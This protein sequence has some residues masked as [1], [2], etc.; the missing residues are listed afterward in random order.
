MPK[1]FQEVGSNNWSQA[2]ENNRSQADVK[3]LVSDQ[4]LPSTNCWVKLAR[5]WN[6]CF[7]KNVEF[8]EF[9]SHWNKSKT[10]CYRESKWTERGSAWSTPKPSFRAIPVRCGKPGFNLWSTTSPWL[11][12]I[13]YAKLLPEDW[14]WLSEIPSLGQRRDCAPQPRHEGICKVCGKTTLN[15]C[16][17]LFGAISIFPLSHGINPHHQGMC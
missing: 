11:G 16:P 13:C 9:L 5:K 10:F 3:Y 2:D 7:R 12:S 8:L 4:G 14:F 17:A 6:I 15:P 1:Q